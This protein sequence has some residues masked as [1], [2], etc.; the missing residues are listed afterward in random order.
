MLTMQTLVTGNLPPSPEGASPW[1]G[2]EG[3]RA[4]I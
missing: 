4:W 1:E 3:G 2:E